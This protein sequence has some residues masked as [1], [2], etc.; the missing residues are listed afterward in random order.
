MNFWTSGGDADRAR[1]VLEQNSFPEDRFEVFDLRSGALD[2][3]P[4]FIFQER[5]NSCPR[6]CNIH[7]HSQEQNEI[8][9]SSIYRVNFVISF[10]SR[11]RME[12]KKKGKIIIRHV[13]KLKIKN[14]SKNEISLK[15]KKKYLFFLRRFQLWEWIEQSIERLGNTREGFSFWK[16]GRKRKERKKKKEIASLPSGIS[17]IS[18]RQLLPARSKHKGRRVDNLPSVVCFFNVGPSLPELAEIHLEINCSR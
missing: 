5:K 15:I 13:R 1:R 16:I 4:N 6:W 7:H 3:P 8:W 12:R 14:F 9:K 11:R 2:Y 10:V 17:L 18:T